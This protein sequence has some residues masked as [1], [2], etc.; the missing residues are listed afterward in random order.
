MD[1]ELKYKIAVITGGSVGI[2]QAIS[3]GLAKAGV[4]L[5]LVARGEDRVHKVAKEIAA[6]FGVRA[7][8]IEYNPDMVELSKR[9]ALKVRVTNRVRSVQATLFDSAFPRAPVLTMFLLDRTILPLP[10]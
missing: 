10:P 3:E 8:G 5:A 7:I 6:K 9:N 2:G 4:H 1:M